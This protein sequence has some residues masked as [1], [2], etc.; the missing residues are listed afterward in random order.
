MAATFRN[1]SLGR[2][3]SLQRQWRILHM[4]KMVILTALLLGWGMSLLMPRAFSVLDVVVSNLDGKIEVCVKHPP[5]WGEPDDLDSSIVEISVHFLN[6]L[7]EYP[8]DPSAKYCILREREWWPTVKSNYHAMLWFWGPCTKYTVSYSLL[9]LVIVLAIAVSSIRRIIL[10]RREPADLRPLCG[11]CGYSLRHNLSGVCP[12][13]GT[14][15]LHI[16]RAAE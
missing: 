3:E 8:E 5:A 10:R 13:C 16:H 15:V 1:E 6:A 9:L 14:A 7:Y 11:R 12:E 4:L 2:S